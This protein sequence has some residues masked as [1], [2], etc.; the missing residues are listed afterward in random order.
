[1]KTNKLFKNF[2]ALCTFLAFITTTIAQ[3]TVS[4]TV[5]D[6]GIDAPLPGASVVELSDICTDTKQVLPEAH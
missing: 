6:A 1:M 5:M 4:G 3:T 2:I